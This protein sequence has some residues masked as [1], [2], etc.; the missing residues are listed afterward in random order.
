[1]KQT[2][3]K[4][5]CLFHKQNG[6]RE[7]HY[8]IQ[9]IKD[10]KDVATVRKRILAILI[11]MIFVMQ[12][13]GTNI[14]Y[15]EENTEPK[16]SNVMDLKEKGIDPTDQFSSIA[17]K[18]R[19]LSDGN[20]SIKYTM[21]LS[22][23]YLNDYRNIITEK[24]DN[25]E[26][27][28][29]NFPVAEDY[30]TTALYD[31][32]VKE[33]FD[34]YYPTLEDSV[35]PTPEVQITYDKE[36][37]DVPEGQTHVPLYT[38]T[39]GEK[40]GSCDFTKDTDGNPVFTCKFSKI[41]Y[42]RSDVDLQFA[43]NYILVKEYGDNETVVPVW[44]DVNKMVTAQIVEKTEGLIEL[45]ADYQ[46]QEK[47]LPNI[48]TPYIDFTVNAV[49]QD[50]Y[51]N[52]QTVVDVIP[53]GL[54]VDSV[55]LDG[56]VLGTNE[57]SVRE[58]IFNY[59]FPSLTKDKSNAMTNC[60]FVIRLFLNASNYKKLMEENNFKQSFTNS[61]YLM[62]SQKNEQLT[63]PSYATSLIRANYLEKKGMQEDLYGAKFKW[64]VS[65]NSYFN[66]GTK[67]FIV[68]SINASAHTYDFTS[69]V[70]VTGADD[71]LIE[72]LHPVE[73]QSNVAYEDLTLD[74]INRLT[75]V[76]GSGSAKQSIYYT[77]I[78]SN[79]M[80]QSVLIIP[81]DKYSNKKINL[82]YYT[83]NANASQSDS[84]DG[85][86]ASGAKFNNKAKLFWDNLV[87]NEET[88]ASDIDVEVVRNIQPAA[89]VLQ[90]T[91]NSYEPSKSEITWNLSINK[92]SGE[93]DDVIIS[94][95]LDQRLQKFQ[96]EILDGTGAITASYTK[97]GETTD[98]E[99]PSEINKVDG[100][101]YYVV[102]D[103]SNPNKKELQVVIGHVDAD[104]SYEI[105]LQTI[106][107]QKK[108][109]LSTAPVE[110][111]NIATS[112]ALCNGVP[113]GNESTA[114]MKLSN[115]MIDK[116]G[117][118][119][120]FK[121]T[122]GETVYTTYNHKDHNTKWRTT[123]NENRVTLTDVRAVETLPEGSSLEKISAINIYKEDDSVLYRI[124]STDGVDF[125]INGKSV[126]ATVVEGGYALTLPN[127]QTI[128]WKETK[129]TK[130]AQNTSIE[131]SNNT[132]ELTFSD[133]VNY[134]LE[135][136]FYTK[137]DEIYRKEVIANRKIVS[138]AVVNVYGKY[139]GEEIISM[140]KS[141]AI[142][143]LPFVIEKKGWYNPNRGTITWNIFVNQDC[144]ELKDYSVVEN[145][146]NEFEMDFS[147]FRVCTFDVSPIGE[148]TDFI[149]VTEDFKD[150]LIENGT[151][152]FELKIP[153]SYKKT[154][155]RIWFDTA[156]TD[157]IVAKDA[158]NQASLNKGKVQYR[159]SEIC[160]PSNMI[161]FN[162]DEFINSSLL[163]SLFVTKVSS[164]KDAS[165]KQNILLSDTEFKLTAMKLTSDGWVEDA[166]RYSKQ[167][168]TKSNGDAVF[169]N[170]EQG[171]LYKLEEGKAAAGYTCSD[172]AKYVVFLKSGDMS[173]TYPE[174]ALQVLPNTKFTR[175]TLENTPAAG[176]SF[177]LKGTDEKLLSG[178]EF[179]LSSE[180]S[181][182]ADKVAVSDENGNV[183]FE[184]LDPGNYTLT[185]VKVPSGYKGANTLTVRITVNE[186]GSVQST[187]DEN[188]SVT[189][190]DVNSIV[191]LN[192]ALLNTSTEPTVEP[193]VEPSEQPSVEPS[194]KPDADVR[195][196]LVIINT[197]EDNAREGFNYRITGYTDRGTQFCGEYTT[198]A[199]GMII[200]NDL[201]CGTYVVQELMGAN[202][203][204]YVLPLPQ[205]IKISQDN[206]DQAKVLHFHNLLVK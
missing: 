183:N 4:I 1:M 171:V 194:K 148:R 202:T 81:A 110:F 2:M 54:F 149:D 127:G 154:P 200:V 79:G 161:N 122:K 52:G 128:T 185:E 120:G 201:E 18:L 147:T 178:G 31:N 152:G 134:K 5:I 159:K 126:A 89:N 13:F 104:E 135:Y 177:K 184:A 189:S 27:S 35:L 162:I 95:P 76:S 193:S 36:Y 12:S 77:Y 50:G 29:E 47:S 64:N 62:D 136:E 179:K 58:G 86:L 43:L 151:R 17:M 93:F 172:E 68:D 187:I 160:I 8:L 140:R 99:I 30:D 102:A 167:R 139:D 125:L 48:D 97:A 16:L 105:Y 72:I 138:L 195:G 28:F 46:I 82:T 21:N 39:T 119:Q 115:N 150:S 132:L 142:A 129:G 192:E 196:T 85:I 116:I 186:D 34:S 40:I 38:F 71:N 57:Y 49:S 19:L 67:A 146:K 14:A 205:M 98:I 15:A 55:A 165:N 108:F 111:T 88:V 94:D 69:G 176:L 96:D 9:Q 124:T 121:N 65:V 168:T 156:V 22:N 74:A 155:I 169:F 103:T 173:S 26:L 204:S 188:E 63:P 117:M 53:E 92:M 101:P 118:S 90:K 112:S 206:A 24:K 141:N 59:T 75:S 20:A 56:N 130:C 37:Y 44:N 157:N 123:I 11:C 42:N 175:I 109:F 174:E 70:E 91:F 61:V 80:K 180:N 6:N 197:A 143:I 45:D 23:N 25:G 203:A 198:D 83:A 133:P 145:L 182:I 144:I 84:G 7:V 10:R 87:L 181:N 166:S 137:Y 107:K 33:Y 73:K 3:G 60:Q 106:I 78:D 170:L 199:F 114:T 100:K 164:T 51:L 158:Q 163:S 191:V 113:C 32:A 66:Q 153:E 41:V 131:V 190:D